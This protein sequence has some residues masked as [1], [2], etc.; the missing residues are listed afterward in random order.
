[1]RSSV[2]CRGV[3]GVLLALSW[4]VAAGAQ[5]PAP[6][7]SPSARTIPELEAAIARSPKDP[8]PQVALGLAYLS[9]GQTDKAVAAL[10]K[11][12]AIGPSFAGAHNWLGVAL[13]EKADLPGAIAALRQAVALDPKHPRAQT[14]LGA[15]LVKGGDYAEAV[16]VFRRALALEPNSAAAQMNL[17]MALRESGES[18][19]ALT[20]LRRVAAAEPGDAGVQYELGQALRQAGD[21]PA[22]AAAFERAVA[23]DPELREGYYGLGQVLKQQGAA[24]RASAPPASGPAVEAIQRAREA[25]ARGDG[26]TARQLLTD[27]VR[28]D[29]ANPDV[30]TLLGFVLGQQG[31]LAAA[32]PHLER[33]VALRPASSEA[34]YNLGAALWFGGAKDRAVA[35][36]RESVRLDPANGAAHAF[37]GTALRDQGD[38]AGARASLQRAIAVL[39]STA[40]VYVDLGIVYC[41]LGEVANALGQFEAGMNAPPP[42]RPEPDWD[43]AVAALRQQIAAKPAA[44]AQHVLG[45]L[46][47][48]QGASGPEVVAAFQAAAKLRPEDAAIHNHLGLALIQTGD[49]PGGIAELREAVRLAPDYA[50]ARTN[51]GAAL[52]PTDAAAAI[53]E[54]EAA[55]ALVPG[56]VKAQFNLAM[57]YGASEAHGPSREIPQLR[58]VI[59]LA[60]AFPR[61]RVALGKALLQGGQ[62]PEAVQQLEEAVRLDPR[63]GE[64]NYQLGLALAR[65]GRADE[66]SAALKKGRDLV[67]AADRDQSIALDLAEGRAALGRG[68]REQA[69]AR[70]QRALRKQPDAAAQ[71]QLASEIAR[72]SGT[73]AS[74]PAP[75]AA[76][77]AP[78]ATSPPP[79]AAPAVTSRAA[80]AAFVDDPARQQE[81]EGLIRD[82]KFAEAEPQLLAYVQQRPASS[83]G[84]YA[85]GYSYFAQQ[86][87]GEA[88]K[89]LAQSLQLDLHNAE[90]HK[91]LGRTLMIIGRFDAARTEF[92][93]AQRDKPDSAEIPYNLGKLASIQDNWPEAKRGFE[94]ALKIDPAYVEALDGLGFAQEALGDD[95]AAVVSYTKAIAVNDER[96]GSFA[97]AHVSLAAYHNRTGNPDK[98]RE[99]A[100]Q[101]IALDPKSDRAWF[102]KA[103][104]D[105]R[106]EKLS[107]AVAA[108]NS[109][110]AL[111]PR[112]SS[113]YYVLAGVYR[114]LGWKDD[115]AEAL[116]M[117]QKLEQESRELDE[118]RRRSGMG[119]APRSDPDRD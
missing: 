69:E 68:E 76:P 34:Q 92:E 3:A 71:Q 110:I 16:T 117:F 23:I 42:A 119:P 106:Q 109:A 1:M 18:T 83:W 47:G 46:L 6:A 73:P 11:A 28:Q 111:N 99:L 53:R 27:A 55:V 48:R 10:K 49:D 114:R 65:A 90:A 72:L 96:K 70:F 32:R 102:Q 17:G 37:L 50:D 85:L 107:D 36:L 14:N 103:K 118:K 116:R 64:A 43:A 8:A 86:K 45:L 95:A 33:A 101:A 9:E 84:W 38:L 58:K 52:T 67:A 88:I 79:A 44:D 66:A 57:A 77:V 93:A 61:A 59:E 56:S 82:Q 91:I 112:A 39:P 94:A 89:A 12:V 19:E 35:A 15:A 80:T 74:A 81:L 51:L 2:G 31:D 20:Y 113:Y 104:A 98:A 60:P 29:E 87:V 7:P 41:R 100:M 78:A 4:V 115:S 26:A 75:E 13:M 25:M 97:G 22:A 62:V 108:L 30:H 24:G 54:L 5:A 21:L 105:E 63:S 40:A